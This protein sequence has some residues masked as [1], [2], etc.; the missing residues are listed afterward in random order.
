MTCRE[1]PALLRRKGRKLAPTPR[2]LQQPP[3]DLLQGPRKVW[4]RALPLFACFV[5]PHRFRNGDEITCSSGPLSPANYGGC[6]YVVRQL[7]HSHSY[8]SPIFKVVREKRYKAVYTP[9]TRSPTA[10]KCA[11]VRGSEPSN[12][13]RLDVPPQS[14]S[15]SPLETLR[16]IALLSVEPF[17][18]WDYP[19]TDPIS[20]LLLTPTDDAPQTP[21]ASRPAAR[22][23]TTESARW[24]SRLAARTSAATRAGAL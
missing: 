4:A 8:V 5:L 21:T 10:P 14:P 13:D 17:P 24:H 7:L 11:L 1:R 15:A 12:I 19:R 16:A 23:F 22:L 3:L 9:E 6:G 2:P 20:S 18:A